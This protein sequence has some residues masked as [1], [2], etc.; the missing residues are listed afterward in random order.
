MWVP[1]PEIYAIL[2]EASGRGIPVIIASSDA[3]ELEGLCDKVLVMSRGHVVETLTG[4]EITEERIVSAAVSAR[5][6]SVSVSEVANS[7]RSLVGIRR[8]IQGDYAP[9]SPGRAGH[10]R[11]SAA[12][13]WARIPHTCRT[14]TVSNLLTAATALGFIA[15]GQNI[16][17]LTGGI[18]LSVGPLAG[19]L[20]VVASFFVN[21]GKPVSMVIIGL[22]IMI[23]RGSG[24]W[25][26]KWIAD[27]VRQVHADSGDAGAVHCPR[28]VRAAASPAAGRLHQP[29]LPG[30]HQHIVRTDS[31]VLH[32]LRRA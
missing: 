30:L 29:G 17:L 21:D 10:R 12:T 25:T 18:D 15:M 32:H 13:C 26:D 1:A 20:V 9:S 24:G 11:S 28:R 6:E 5:T 16:S 4:D 14:T 27:Q 7:G 23:A 2:R 8:F 22:V 3:K 19:F 31:V